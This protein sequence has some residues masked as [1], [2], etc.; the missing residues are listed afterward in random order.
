MQKSIISHDSLSA[1]L[2]KKDPVEAV[3]RRVM[4]GPA[5]EGQGGH[6]RRCEVRVQGDLLKWK[7]RCFSSAKK[8]LKVQ[9]W[10]L[11][12]YYNILYT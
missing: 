3:L 11:Y 10:H 2:P 8:A 5:L 6:R 9:V 7:P 1:I 4:Q 12:I